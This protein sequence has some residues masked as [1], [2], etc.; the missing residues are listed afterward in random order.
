MALPFHR[1][2]GL[3]EVVELLVADWG[4]L[5]CK[6]AGGDGVNSH[7]VAGPLDCKLPRE[8][9]DGTLGGGVLGDTHAEFHVHPNGAEHGGDVY[10]AAVT[11]PDHDLAE[12]TAAVEEA[13]Y[14]DVHCG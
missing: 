1:T 2:L 6:E 3:E 10:H 13:V 8:V 7:T 12:L 14:I 9:V 11:I 4:D 5:T